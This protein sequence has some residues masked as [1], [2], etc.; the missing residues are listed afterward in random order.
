V[1]EDE[2]NGPCSARE[3]SDYKFLVRQLKKGGHWED[4]GRSLHLR[5]SQ[6]SLLKCLVP[7][8]DVFRLLLK[9][10]TVRSSET[11]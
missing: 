6:P 5:F 10:E 9:M 2:V 7:G 4:L 3:S 11:S 8:C 1:K